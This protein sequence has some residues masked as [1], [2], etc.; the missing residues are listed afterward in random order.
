M[1]NQFSPALPGPS[2]PD[3]CCPFPLLGENRFL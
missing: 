3:L 2:L 1:L